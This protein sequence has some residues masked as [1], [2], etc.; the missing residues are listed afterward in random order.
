MYSFIGGPPTSG[1]S[2]LAEEIAKECGIQHVYVDRLRD[3][4][5]ISNP[6][7]KLWRDFFNSKDG[8]YWLSVT[9]K[10][11]L[12]DC[13]NQTLALWKYIFNEITDLQ[14]KYENI[15][16]EGVDFLP[17]ITRRDLDF[18]GIFIYCES[19]DESY[20]RN[21]LHPRIGKTEELQKREAIL[22]AEYES[23]NIKDLAPKY[24]YQI[25]TSK[26]AFTAKASLLTM[27]GLKT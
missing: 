13:R 21:K 16:F 8:E 24:G 3:K 11:Y 9:K 12:N 17:D 6:K 25:F 7:L 10:Q 1:K 4:V 20:Q 19:I 18:D 2:Y 22:Y 27:L 15:I 23:S 26:N 5:A 14:K